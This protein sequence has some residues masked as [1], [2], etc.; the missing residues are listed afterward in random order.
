MFEDISQWGESC[1]MQASQGQSGSAHVVVLGNE[2]G[3]SGKSTTALHIAVASVESR[4]ARRHHRS[5][6]PPAEL[7]PATST[8]AAPGP[9]RT[10][11]DLELPVHCCI[12]SARPCRSPTTRP[13]NSSNSWMPSARSSAPSIS[14]SSIRP[15]SDSYLMRLAHSMADTLVTPIN[16][17]FLDFDVL[18]TVDPATYAVT[19]E[20]HYAEMVRD[21]RRKRRQLDGASTDWIVVR[22][23]LSMIGSR[24]KQL[25]RRRPQGA[26]VPARL[27]LDRRLCRARGLPRVLP[28]RADRARR[29]RRGDARHPPEHGPRHGAR[30]G[31]Q[32]AAPV[33]AAARRAR[34]PPRR[35]PRRM[36]QP[37]RQAARSSTTSSAPERLAEPLPSPAARQRPLAP[38]LARLK[39]S[40]A[41]CHS[42]FTAVWAARARPRL[43]ATR[44]SA[45]ARG[46]MPGSRSISASPDP[47]DRSHRLCRRHRS[48]RCRADHQQG[49]WA[50][51]GVRKVAED[52]RAILGLTKADLDRD[53]GGAARR[54]ELSSLRKQE[55]YVQAPRAIVGRHRSR[56][57]RA[58][59]DGQIGRLR[60]ARRIGSAS[61]TTPSRTTPMI[62]AVLAIVQTKIGLNETSG[63]CPR[64]A[65]RVDIVEAG[66]SDINDPKLTGRFSTMRRAVRRISCCGAMSDTQVNSRRPWWPSRSC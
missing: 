66:V 14:S 13:P 63:S 25:R 20:S 19:G 56:F 42:S 7:S 33:E 62:F 35:Q 18:G 3:G 10:G 43:R 32:P 27:P 28:A 40:L 29:H 37:G 57:R 61:S 36:V 47:Q 38:C 34:P 11:L 26:V 52:A 21:I 44:F 48:R 17:S 22:N 9:R 64:C 16:D 39:Q 58:E 31:D 51:D 55:S 46:F 41:M 6:L 60:R 5:R 1:L 30:G 49:T 2:K 65:R 59:S 15:G 50:Q 4:P 54:E 24:N 45:A 8:T 23:R 12:K 53:A